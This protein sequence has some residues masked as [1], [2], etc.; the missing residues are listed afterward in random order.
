MTFVKQPRTATEDAAVQ[1][2]AGQP[3]VEAVFHAAAVSDFTFGKVWEPWPGATMAMWANLVAAGKVIAP[4]SAGPAI[5]PFET[6]TEMDFG[7]LGERVLL[8]SGG[9]AT[10]KYESDV[11]APPTRKEPSG[12]VLASPSGALSGPSSTT[13]A[14]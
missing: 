11:V 5:C 6:E 10:T 14:P 1:K 4:A 7:S 13:V 8:A 2:L 9:L 3:T 12:P